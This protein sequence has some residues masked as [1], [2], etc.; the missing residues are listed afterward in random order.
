MSLTI[1]TT[2]SARSPASTTATVT[3]TRRCRQKPRRS[4][5]SA[6]A[7]VAHPTR[8]TSSPKSKP[9]A[10]RSATRGYRSSRK[11]GAAASLYRRFGG[12][13][14]VATGA[15]STRRFPTAP[16]R[17]MKVTT[18]SSRRG[19]RRR[20]RSLERLVAPCKCGEAIHCHPGKST[21]STSSVLRFEGP[22]QITDLIGNITVDVL[23]PSVEN[24]TG[25]DPSTERVGSAKYD[26]L[27]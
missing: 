7:S 3:T 6:R 9:W 10:E 22:Y 4:L 17:R 14:A 27:R 2:S 19:V 5:P 12:T 1:A 8:W 15:S 18:T 21:D 11:D 25:D 20:R 13:A 26:N 16:R 23:F 24:L